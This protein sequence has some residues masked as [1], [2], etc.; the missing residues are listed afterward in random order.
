MNKASIPGIY[1]YKQVVDAKLFIDSHF[2]EKIDLELIAN[3][4]CFSKFHFHRVFK[5]CY[6]KTPLQYLTQVR[7]KEAKRLLAEEIPTGEVCF[8]VGFDSVSSFIKLFRRH[9]GETPARYA[10]T[11][12]SQRAREAAAPVNCIPTDFA[13]YL[14]WKS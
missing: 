4:A 9:E 2:S 1:L 5:E 6:N 8:L 14:G 12:R 3:E 13:E 11:I 10:Q 7:I